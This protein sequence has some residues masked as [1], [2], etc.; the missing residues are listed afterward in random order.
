MWTGGTHEENVPKQAAHASSSWSRLERTKTKSHADKSGKRLP[1][2]LLGRERVD[3]H[4]PSHTK[5]EKK[6]STWIDDESDQLED[7]SFY[8]TG[9]VHGV[10]VDFL[11]DTG[12]TVT[13]ISTE[14]FQKINENRP[15]LLE[16]TKRKCYNVNGTVVD[17]KGTMTTSINFGNIG[18]Q[19]EIIVANITTDEAILGANF[20]QRNGCDVML[21]KQVLKMDGE[22]IPLWTRDDSDTV[23][24]VEVRQCTTIPPNSRK[25]VPVKIC[26]SGKLPELGL[27]QPK[28]TFKEKQ[29]VVARGVIDTKTQDAAVQVMNLGN[30]EVKLPTGFTMGQCESISNDYIE[31]MNTSGDISNFV[32][33][34]SDLQ[35]QSETTVPDHVVELFEKSSTQLSQEEKCRLAALLNKYQNVFAKSKTDLGRTNLV[36]H[37]INTGNTHPIKQAPRRQ[38]IE[39][40]DVERKEIED[41][42][43]RNIIEPSSSPW[44]SPVVLIRK[45][46]GDW[47]FCVD[48]RKINA[49]TVP[50]AY[51]IPRID[52]SIDSLAGA[53]WFC[54]MDLCS[55]YWQ[56]EMDPADKEKMAF[57]TRMGLY[58][59]NTMPFGLVNAPATFERLMETVLRGLQWEECLVYIGDVI[60]FGQSVDMCLTRLSHI[61]ERLQN[62][63][64]KL[65]PDK[66]SFFQKEVLFLG[67]VVSTDGVKTDPSK[68]EAVRD[69]PVPVNAKQVRSFLGLAGYY[70]RFVQHFSHKAAPLYKLTEKGA[71]FRWTQECQEAFETL[72]EALITT[73]ILSYPRAE[74]QYILDT[75][76]SNKA[77]G[78][79]LQQI[80]DGKEKVIAY[81]SK[82]LSRA[83]QR[84]CVTRKEMLAVVTALKKFKHYLYGRRIELRTDNSAVNY[85]RN[86]KE[87][88]GQMARWIEQYQTYDIHS[89]HR[90]GKR[91]INA[92]ALSRRP[93]T[94]CGRPDEDITPKTEITV[95]PSREQADLVRIITRGQQKDNNTDFRPRQGWLEGWEPV[96]IRAAQEA[97]RDLE[98]LFKALDEGR[99]RPKWQDISEYSCRL[100]ALW[101]QWTRL[102]MIGGVMYRKWVEEETDTHYW[103]LVVPEGKQK[104]VLWHFHDSPTAGHLGSSR[105]MM[106][107]RHNFYWVG[108]KDDVSR[109]CRRCDKCAARK[110][111]QKH[112]RGKL[113]Q[114]MVGEPMERMAVDV[115]GPLPETNRGNK[116]I[117][118][119]ADYFSKWVE[120]FAMPD[121]T[122]ETIA[123][124]MVEEVVCRFGVPLQIHSDQGT[125]FESRLY[126]DM[127]KMLGIEKSRT[128]GLHPISD[129][130][131]ERYN[132]T[133]L[134][135]LTMY[136]QDE[137]KTW[138]QHLPFVMMAYRASVQESSGFTPNQLMLG[139]DVRLPLTAVV[140]TPAE[141]DGEAVEYETYVDAMQE[142]SRKAHDVARKHLRKAAT[143]QKQQYDQKADKSGLDEG[144]AVWL[145][146]PSRKRGV[147]PKLTS[148]WKGPFVIVQKIDD[149]LYKIQKNPRANA[150]V[151]HLNRLKPYEGDDAPKWFK[152]R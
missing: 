22:I 71:K 105:T 116:Y 129:G 137:Q 14:T 3:E 102:K 42:L 144:Q 136:A 124:V 59:F 143:H 53:K 28:D 147:C 92:D 17:F 89:S 133:L 21:S 93:C 35:N 44:A 54:T 61:F 114:Y 109:Y 113:R 146:D 151:V 122:A 106:K 104:E 128:T 82:S 103:Q 32:R 132:R 123:R 29:I 94:Q 115:L 2:R 19:Q 69:W 8:V 13:I 135:M 79:V 118:V 121:Q 52:E 98:P 57:T 40:R 140:P 111:T 95:Q 67:H 31:E 126:R 130:L 134:T 80:Q 107:I 30:S 66:C 99:E 73:P 45:K 48:Y 117:L 10:L 127:L 74:G 60:C 34:L 68:I 55:G 85:V 38:P 51:P 100:K 26:Q 139:R 87:P 24:R 20:L 76:A 49:S 70:R 97:D 18:R 25:M 96:Q 131:V 145:W 86:I 84:Y 101:R 150:K 142:K 4:R 83:E 148:K 78:A 11:V 7:H 16:P 47:R 62:A 15:T 37:T 88:E 119:V 77:L 149:L 43:E 36:K 110:P 72:K 152:R 6:I 5:F 27:I 91:H 50:D 12:A 141:E 108:L 138:D 33:S 64:L 120:A 125:N 63:G 65:R 56:V 9:R 23:S 58:Q 81:M 1:T 75:D 90:P 39:R 112:H 46:S 41:M